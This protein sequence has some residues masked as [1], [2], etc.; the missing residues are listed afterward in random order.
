MHNGKTFLTKTLRR[1]F[2][3]FQNDRSD[4]PV[5]TNCKRPNS[6]RI[7]TTERRPSTRITTR[8]GTSTTHNG[9]SIDRELIS[10]F[11]WRY[12][13]DF[14]LQSFASLARHAQLP[15]LNTKTCGAYLRKQAQTK[16]MLAVEPIFFFHLTSKSPIKCLFS[17]Y[18]QL[19][20]F[21]AREPC[22][23]KWFP[24]QKC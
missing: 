17:D 15:L 9:G 22:I 7:K 18:T 11:T 24:H 23:L 1:S 14:I 12:S 13:I 20:S 16:T 3:H 5:L 8:T 4:R 10:F 2:F 19:L 21:S 6:S